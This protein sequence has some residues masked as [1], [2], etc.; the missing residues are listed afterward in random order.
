MKGMPASVSRLDISRNASSSLGMP[1]GII[2]LAY[3]S[4][5][6]TESRP[7]TRCRPF[8]P[9]VLSPRQREVRGKLQVLRCRI[10]HYP[11]IQKRELQPYTNVLLE[12]TTLVLRPRHPDDVQELQRGTANERQL[13]LTIERDGVLGLEVSQAIAAELRDVEGV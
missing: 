6:T 8:L 5:S 9:R 12:I 1:T 10:H 7:L 3:R 13:D 2:V 11:R 4:R